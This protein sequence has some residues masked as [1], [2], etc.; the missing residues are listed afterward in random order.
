MLGLLLAGRL[1]GAGRFDGGVKLARHGARGRFRL[2]HLGGQAGHLLLGRFQLGAGGVQAAVQLA[3]FADVLLLRV[4]VAQ[5]VAGR[6]QSLGRVAGTAH[7]LFQR[8]GDFVQRCKHY[9]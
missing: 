9:L 7:D 5:A 6:P 3:E 2:F 4:Q 1:Q 8:A